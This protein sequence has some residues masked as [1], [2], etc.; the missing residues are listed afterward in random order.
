MI[1]SARGSNTLTRLFPESGVG[2]AWQLHSAKYC[3]WKV[4]MHASSMQLAGRGGDP[5]PTRGPG[6]PR[7][8]K[9]APPS[10]CGVV[11]PHQPLCASPPTELLLLQNLYSNSTHQSLRFA[12]RPGGTSGET[13]IGA[14]PAAPRPSRRSS[15]P[16]YNV[17]GRYARPATEFPQPAYHSAAPVVCRVLLVKD[18]EHRHG[19]ERRRCQIASSWQSLVLLPG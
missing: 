17:C 14:G 9:P 4:P 2:D 1:T 16:W 19:L 5:T 10:V 15:Q 11:A 18:G 7:L 3:T 13:G 6:R 12:S 8:H